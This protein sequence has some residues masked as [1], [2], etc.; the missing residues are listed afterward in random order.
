MNVGERAAACVLYTRSMYLYAGEWEC[1]VSEWNECSDARKK[2]VT[3]EQ[4]SLM[5]WNFVW[6]GPWQRHTDLNGNSRVF[7]CQVNADARVARFFFCLRCR[8]Q[9][10]AGIGFERSMKFMR[11]MEYLVGFL[12]RIDLWRGLENDIR[13]SILNQNI[14]W[15]HIPSPIAAIDPPAHMA[16]LII[17]P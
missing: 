6:K 15:F 9:P 4:C 17:S 3:T 14:F 2:F 10:C 13:W 5:R 1:F 16:Y 12:S 7:Y 11:N 8:C